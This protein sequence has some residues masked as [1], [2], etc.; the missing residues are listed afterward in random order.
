MYYVYVLKLNNR[1]MYT[2]S[3]NDLK[4][5]ISEHRNGKVSS[6]KHKLPIKL[7][8]YEGYLLKSDAQ[9]REKFLKTTEGKRL[10]KQQIRDILK[11]EN[12]L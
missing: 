10:L 8:L 4:R 12:I 6:T 3:T 1:L 5:R 7:L 2:G 9:R 11:I